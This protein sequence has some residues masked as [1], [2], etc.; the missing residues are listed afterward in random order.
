MKKD[1][2]LRYYNRRILIWSL[3]AL[4]F[5]ALMVAVLIFIAANPEDVVLRV[6]NI[7]SSFFFGTSLGQAVDLIIELH[8]Y[9]KELK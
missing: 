6:L 2:K 3:A 7:T 1:S 9:K 5:L 8:T 4:S